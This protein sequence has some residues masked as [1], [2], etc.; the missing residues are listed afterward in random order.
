MGNQN[1]L[2]TEEQDDWMRVHCWGLGYIEIQALLKS[3]F[4]I[5]FTISQVKGYINR[6]KIKTGRTGRFSKGHV[7]ATKGTKMSPERYAKIK[8]TMFKKGNKPHNTVP[9]GTRIIDSD[10]YIKEKIAEPN[11]W[12]F[13]HRKIWE[14]TYG[15]VPKKH[16]I[17]FLDGN[18][19][20]C[21]ISNL[22]CISCADNSR[23]NASKMRS[24]DG[25]I[26]RAAIALIQLKAKRDELVK[27]RGEKQK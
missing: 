19:S 7:P 8:A 21:D 17:T 9:V 25:D 14:N 23:L 27:K 15:P 26:T 6:K 18:R 5:E 1:R 2:T 22:I 24:E 11:Q 16:V 4:G 10:G 20:N 3:Q 12:V 13:P